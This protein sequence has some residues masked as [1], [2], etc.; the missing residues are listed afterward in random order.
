MI[1]FNIIIVVTLPSHLSELAAG[2]FV[3]VVGGVILE[4]LKSYHR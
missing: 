4:K 3:T 2:L 1:V